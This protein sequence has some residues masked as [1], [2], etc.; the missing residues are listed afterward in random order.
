MKPHLFAAALLASACLS[1]PAP[2][3][4]ISTAAQ[5]GDRAIA[6]H[7]DRLMRARYRADAPGGAVLVARG[8]KV[9]FR[10]A[11]GKGDVD[12]NVPLRPDS[13]FRIGSVTKQFAAAGLLKLVEAGKVKLDDPVAK[14]LPGFPGG[15]SI[16]ILHLLNHT[17]GVANYTAIA[18]YMGEPVRRDLTTAQM[19]DVFKQE[20]PDF[21]PG[22]GWNYS[23]SGYVLVGAVIEAVSGLP[24]HDYLQ[25]ALFK[26]LGMKNTGYAHDPVRVAKQVRGYSYQE[27][28]L[29]PARPISM[30]QPHAAGSLLSNVNDLLKWNRALHEGRVLKSATYARMIS[31]TGKA[32][33]PGYGFGLFAGTVRNVPTLWHG[34]GIFGFISS[35]HYLPG[36]DISIVVLEN[37]DQDDDRRGG[38]SADSF[39][40][41]LA[42]VALGQ[43]YP[44]MRPVVV[45]TA[46]LRALEGVYQFGDEVRRILR[47]VDG[48]L[49]A[50][51]GS[52]GEPQPLI[53]IA[54]DDFL[55]PDGFNRLKVERD[56]G[57]RIKG[58]R[59]F[60]GGDG[61]GQVGVRT[62]EP[63]P[64]A[65]L[66]GA[67]LERVTGAYAHE[68][69]GLAL[70]V[71]LEGG[72]LLA[73][74]E[75]QPP[76]TLRPKSSTLFDV[77]ETGA[78]LEFP[79]GDARREQV[80]MRQGGREIVL[81]RVP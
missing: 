10:S 19:I 60:A 66:P 53:P 4:P 47:L 9:L 18:N 2:A 52:R 70:K 12:A 45:D 74:I 30:T 23:N 1:M 79:A 69:A 55:Y 62:G 80:T 13:V 36:P 58:L 57:G 17:S 76:V 26:P 46:S 39:A 51:R 64:G 3:K 41:K 44:E 35:L 37:D 73:Q 16:T 32:A 71:Y 72:A 6:H 42:A 11:I 15:G 21:A 20:K 27:G 59:F 25:R 8:D 78:S 63:L 49:M 48:R 81:K 38:E 77:E 29:V 33:G 50:Q 67:A 28:R 40:R 22:Q 68:G 43:P 34:G 31:P 24:W 7:A 75:G 65:A 14:H 54:A 5:S 61:E 56:T